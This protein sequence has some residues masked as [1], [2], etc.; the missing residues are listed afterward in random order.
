MRR[1]CCGATHAVEESVKS[2]RV[3]VRR[4]RWMKVV[5]RRSDHLLSFASRGGHYIDILLARPI[6][7]EHQSLEVAREI[8]SFD[9][10]LTTRDSRGFRQTSRS[11]RRNIERPDV[12]ALSKLAV[13]QCA[14]VGSDGDRMHLLP[15]R[16]RNGFAID[17]ALRADANAEQISRS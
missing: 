16:E 5:R 15:H 6:R 1:S 12:G 11:M 3:S 2:D 13:R 14:A 4:P 17:P 10:L 7:V 8:H 9:R